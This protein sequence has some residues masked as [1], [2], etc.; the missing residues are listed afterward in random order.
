MK[1]VVPISS[2]D[3]SEVIGIP[4]NGVDIIVYN[5]RATKNRTYNMQLLEDNLRNLSIGDDFKKSF[6]FSCATIFAPTQN[7]KGCMTCVT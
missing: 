4:N 3:V 1:I 2:K 6:I 5:R 7:L